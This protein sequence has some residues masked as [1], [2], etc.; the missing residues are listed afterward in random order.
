MEMQMRRQAISTL[1]S[2][3]HACIFPD[4]LVF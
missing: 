3:P 1:K 2:V 4:V